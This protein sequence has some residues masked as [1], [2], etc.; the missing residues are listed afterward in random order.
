MLL[1]LWSYIRGY[2]V[3]EVTGF[4]IERFIN[5]ATYKGV[6][7]WD[8]K[9]HEKG[10]RMKI[11]VKAFKILKVCA[12]KTKCKIKII[13]KIG[14]PFVLYK[15]RKRKILLG[16]FAFFIGCLYLLSSFVWLIEIEGNDRILTE[17]IINF[18]NK[19][20]LKI[21]ALK[22]NLNTKRLESNMIKE[23]ADI[24]WINVSVYGTKVK[25]ELTEILPKKDLIDKNSP[26]NIV[27]R[28]NGLITSIVTSSGTPLVKENDVVEKGDLLVSGELKV[29]GQDGENI[30]VFVNSKAEIWGKMYYEINYKVPYTY[31]KKRY[32]GKVK[33]DKSLV[34]FNKKIN[35]IG[36]KIKFDNYDKNTSRKQLKLTDKYPLPLIL[37][38]D[39]YV[40]FTPIELK[41]TI[42]EAK[43]LSQKILTNRL[44]REFNFNAD[45]IG[46]DINYTK[47]EEGL[48]VK[49]LIT[50]LERIDEFQEIDMSEYEEGTQE[51]NEQESNVAT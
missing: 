24:S 3:I 36:K 8:M 28:K 38:R 34:V 45:I 7:I 18:V 16:G 15:Y 5:L 19:E 50:T 37:V 11:S 23:F 39:E 41:Y 2:V 27:A 20:G 14:L 42:E 47:T 35:L 43:E 33:K 48:E 21:G 26:S 46:K 6:Y 13:E 40:E 4:S 25:I 32:T 12:K 17:S 44:I 30:T 22:I 31:I 10:V 49:A 1:T 51:E 9:Y 29:I